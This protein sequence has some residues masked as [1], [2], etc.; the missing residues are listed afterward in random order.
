LSFTLCLPFRQ[1]FGTITRKTHKI[2]SGQN[3][4]VAHLFRICEQIRVT[5]QPGALN[6][7]KLVQAAIDLG[8]LK[9]T[10]WS[11]DGEPVNTT[12]LFAHIH[13]R[14][15]VKQ[16]VRSLLLAADPLSP[17]TETT[18]GSTEECCSCRFDRCCLAR[19]AFRGCGSRFRHKS[20]AWRDDPWGIRA[21]W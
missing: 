20:E 10:V 4:C 9:S 12:R 21:R 19:S 7:E 3:F 1:A 15:V 17:T 16:V 2:G 5:Q 18:V 14:R 6:T 13:R 11:W 8:R